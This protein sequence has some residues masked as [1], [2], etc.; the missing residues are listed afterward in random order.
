MSDQVDAVMS[1]EGGGTP[2]H[3]LVSRARRVNKIFVF[4]VLLP[5]LLASIYYGLI[6]SDV[7][8]SEAR[9]IVR[10]PQRQAQ[11]GLVGALLQGS[12]FSN[13]QDDAYL[14]HDFILSRDALSEL[15]I[16]NGLR[17]KYA[18]GDVD[19][20]SRFPILHTEDSFEAL[21]RFY[22]KHIDVDYDSTSGITTL[23]V[24]A[25]TSID[26]HEINEELM[27]QSERLINR[28]NERATQ[29]M[30]GFASKDVADAEAEVRRTTLAVSEFRNAHAVFDPE[31]QSALQL[32][33]VSTL[34]S[35]L[36]AAK[37]QLVEVQSLSPANPQVSALRTR[38][39]VLKEEI[40]NAVRNVAGTN[41]SLSGKAPEYERLVL[42]KDFAERRFAAALSALESAKGE[43]ERKQL[44][45]ERLVQP[46]SPDVAIEPKRLQSVLVVFALGLIVWGLLTLLVSGIREHQL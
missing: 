26:A 14:V 43:A 10:S 13:A 17:D 8:V 39:D 42:D 46:N 7:Y 36:V 12:A 15:N 18:R 22:Q 30:V 33:Q 35:E 24:R 16:H 9:F 31:R 20:L 4:A 28:L 38:V 40:E 23:R 34:Q 45:L 32:Q 11:S 3:G 25:F 29:D 6:A 19:L 44:Y 37:T 2:L 27:T 1:R 5:T 41:A 21:W